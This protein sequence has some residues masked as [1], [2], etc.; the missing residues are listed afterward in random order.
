MK[1][2]DVGKEVKTGEADSIA[3][4]EVDRAEQKAEGDKD[5]IPRGEDG[6]D[7]GEKAES[8]EESFARG[9][10]RRFG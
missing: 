10:R 8:G 9:R 1:V 7:G 2:S 3:A 6:A 4:A 5:G